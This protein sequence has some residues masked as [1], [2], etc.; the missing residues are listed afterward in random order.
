MAIYCNEECEERGE[1]IMTGF[2]IRC[3]NCNTESKHENKDDRM[4]ENTKIFI[5]DYTTICFCC[6]KCGQRTV[7]I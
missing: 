6:D 5:H 1:N 2:V 7:L 3:C 4:I